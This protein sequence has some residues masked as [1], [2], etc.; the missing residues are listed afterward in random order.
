MP[1]LA[2]LI[3]AKTRT[4]TATVRLNGHVW[5]AIIS[6]SYSQAFGS[7][8]AGGSVIGRDPPVEPVIGMPLSWT[9]G[10]NGVEIAG[11]TGEIA[12]PAR[13]SYPNRYSLECRDVLWRADRVQQ[14]IA[15][16][17]LNT[18][19]AKAAIVYILTHYGGIPA[20]RLSIPDL[21]ASGSAWAGTHWTLG[22]LTPVAWGD[23][24]TNT[25]GTTA[26]KACQE[27]CSCLGYWLY[28]DAGGIVRAKQIERRPSSSALRTYT[29]GVDLLVG[30]PPEISQDVDSIKNRIVVLGANTGVEGAQIRDVYQTSH[31]LLP[32]GVYVDDTF[33]SV[34]IEYVNE[35]EAGAASATAIAKRV[36]SVKARVPNVER[37]KAKADPR[38]QVGATVGI[39]D[40]AIGLSAARNFFVYSVERKL[41][42]IKGAFDDQLTL[43][44]GTGSSGYTTIPPPDASFSW[45]LD[46]EGL[47]GTA[48]VAVFL[49]ASAS[50]SLSGGEI[51]SWAW[52]T[53]A[54]PYGGTP[55]SASGVRAVLLFPA[56]PSPVS[57][58]LTVTDTSSKTG[59]IT[60]SIDLAVAAG[61]PI[62]KRTLSVA[63]GAAWAVT[64]DGGLTWATETSGGDAV[65]VPPYG[66][67][68]D[69]R[70][71]ALASSTYGLLA[72]RGS[73]GAGGLRRTLDKLAS[74]SS[75]LASASGA[76]RCL[77][78]NEAN[79]AR[80]WWA[81][82]DTVYRSIDGG[83]TGT[84]MARPAAG[85]NVNWLIEDPAL[86]DSVF[87]AA[88]A[89]IYNTTQPTLSWDV[90]YAGPSGATAR[91]F[92]R[93]RDGQVTWVA[94]TSTF[95]GSPLQRIEGALSVTFPGATSEIRTLALNKDASNLAA[96]IYAIDSASPPQVFAADGIA[97]GSATA[98]ATWPSG[99][100]VMHVLSDP[101]V[102]LLYVADFDSITAGTGAVRK[103][104]PASDALLL[105]KAGATGQ[106]AHMLGFGASQTVAVELLLPTRGESGAGDYLWHYTPSA[107][108]V[109]ITPPSAG[110]YWR[111]VAASPLAPDSWLLL[112]N[113][114]D[115][116]SSYT[117]SGGHVVM[118]DGSTKPLWLTT[119]AGATWTAITLADPAS[120]GTQITLVKAEWSWA[121]ASAWVVV[122]ENEVTATTVWRGTGTTAGA[123]STNDTHTAAVGWAFGADSDLYLAPSGTNRI[124]V[125]QTSGG[126]FTVPSGSAL[127]ENL[128]TTDRL[129]GTRIMASASQGTAVYATG[130]YRASQPTALYDTADSFAAVAFVG[131]DLFIGGRTG[132][133]LRLS[134]YN[135]AVATLAYDTNAVGFL[136]SDRQT[137]TTL[138]VRYGS[139][140]VLVYDGSAWAFLLG[141]PATTLCADAIE[142]I[143]R[144]V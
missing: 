43:D 37:H 127:S 1:T 100:T 71:P 101:D 136:R 2:A 3:A 58:T 9:W 106:Q 45:R 117:V 93:S 131:T 59:S 12:K 4:P 27:I 128:Y 40:A 72:T 38:V 61:A 42:A 87:A 119:D 29:R 66:A 83:A 91:Q 49:D 92:V 70:A 16:D 120:G 96:T 14:V 36:L 21:E 139:R 39:Q 23:S 62:V 89:N 15:T 86:D 95:S 135:A 44:G 60:Q 64:A 121:D 114:A 144:G 20:S 140:D 109:G 47:D 26:L 141:P 110:K 126:S 116:D 52:S 112:G 13:K 76:V 113:S 80:V 129:L 51:V 10:Y 24:D 75:N 19:T 41:D 56:T 103:Y 65:A 134:P 82:G 105:W 6:L 5:R 33:S 22:T 57:I 17:P 122:R 104:F 77:W 123:P 98:G 88:G 67:G 133:V 55:S 81:V 143:K 132:G 90:L 137:Q 73:G 50:A 118:A 32:S 124:G 79:P 68:I 130:D 25:G 30:G 99:A 11:F 18:I 69:S 107:G 97:G 7:G 94:Y 84:A 138:A 48:V 108:W 8:V 111:F 78:V 31:P 74:A 46:R 35:S 125:Y 54:T 34:L 142:V 102:D 53:S 85:T 63:F 28:A 115:N